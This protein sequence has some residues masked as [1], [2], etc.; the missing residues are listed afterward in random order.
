MVKAVYPFQVSVTQ[1]LAVAPHLRG[2]PTQTSAAYGP[3]HVCCLRGVDYGEHTHASHSLH[4]GDVAV[5][6]KF[7]SRIVRH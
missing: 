2:S 6:V 5:F 3:F 7:T 4:H 1:A